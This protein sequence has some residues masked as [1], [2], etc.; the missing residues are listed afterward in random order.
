MKPWE[1]VEMLAK[2]LK[3]LGKYPCV[4]GV[5]GQLI[6]EVGFVLRTPKDIITKRES[7]NLGNIKGEGPA[8]SVTVL[9]HEYYDTVTF[10]QMKARGLIVKYFGIVNGKHKCQVKDKFRAYHNYGEAILD[11][12]SL[13]QK[14][15]YIRAGV[16]LAK[17]PLEFAQALFRAGYATDPN[18]VKNIMS[19]VDKYQLSRFDMPEPRKDDL[20]ITVTVKGKQFAGVLIDAVTWVP[21]REINNFLGIQTGWDAKD[22]EVII[23]GTKLPT[24]IMKFDNEPVGYVPIRRLASA[25]GLKVI[26]D[27]DKRSVTLV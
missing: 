20:S 11:H 1:V 2:E 10:F 25:I 27:A 21:A 6:Q 19:I 12:F 13:L 9:T 16:L 3:A 8:G 15:R 26:W 23:N 5:V 22:K 14:P 4:S 24:R 17:T 18:Y 7:Y